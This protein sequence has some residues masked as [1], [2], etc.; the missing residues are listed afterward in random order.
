MTISGCSGY[1]GTIGLTI[2]NTSY[3]SGSDV[4]KECVC[5]TSA[6][7][8]TYAQTLADGKTALG[9]GGVGGQPCCDGT[10]KTCENTGCTG[11]EG[12]CPAN[13]VSHIIRQQA[14]TRGI[15]LIRQPT[16]AW[17]ILAILGV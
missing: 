7:G 13:A 3:Y 12:S 9:S 8:C 15:L 11:K 1:P 17:K 10:Y 4:C 5:D 16:N 14:V 2:Q 6:S